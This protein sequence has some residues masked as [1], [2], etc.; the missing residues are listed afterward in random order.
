MKIVKGYCEYCKAEVLVNIQNGGLYPSIIEQIDKLDACDRCHI[1]ARN[2]LIMRNK[3]D[4]EELINSPQFNEPR[5][6]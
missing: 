6:K 3:T 5:D 4:K 1:E 2:Y